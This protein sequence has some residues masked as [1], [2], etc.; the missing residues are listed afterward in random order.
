VVHKGHIFKGRPED[1]DGALRPYPEEIPHLNEGEL[2]LGTG[3][4]AF[5][6]VVLGA[7]GKVDLEVRQE[8][9]LA[10][11]TALYRRRGGG[12]TVLLDRGS[13]IVTLHAQV[14]HCFDNGRYFAAL[15]RALMSFLH[16]LGLKGLCQAGLSDIAV[17][18][19]KLVG[20]SMFRRKFHLLFQAS[21]L[22]SPDWSLL[23]Q[24]LPYPPREPDYRK[25][26]DHRSF[27]TCALEEGV[28]PSAFLF[29][30]LEQV[31]GRLFLDE[32]QQDRLIV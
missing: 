29:G 24:C 4:P 17:K 27:L 6:H 1:A 19:K 30:D 5:P 32:M 31:L 25:G 8:A 3:F 21:V 9:A 26:R 7:G 15:N 14:R 20:S 28:S 2:W 10:V 18:G 11:Q 13:W 12:G 16:D 22:V 23:D